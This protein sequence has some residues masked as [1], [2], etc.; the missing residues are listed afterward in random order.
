MGHGAKAS[1]GVGLVPTA[2]LRNGRRVYVGTHHSS[3][4]REI[5]S[6]GMG[7]PAYQQLSQYVPATAW[8]DEQ[9]VPDA[10][11]VAAAVLLRSRRSD[12]PLLAVRCLERRRTLRR[13]HRPLTVSM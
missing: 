12:P 4:N 5:A 8:E 6:H 13:A 1:E 7:P 9:R 3:V 10:H 2:R 11:V